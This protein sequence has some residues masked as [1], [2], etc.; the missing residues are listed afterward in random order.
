MPAGRR[1]DQQCRWSPRRLAEE[2]GWDPKLHDPDLAVAKGAAI[3]ALS[4]V[5]YRM[6]Q[7]ARE[8]AGS[9]A[10]GAERAAEVVQEVA[11]QYGLPAATVEELVDRKGRK[12]AAEGV[13]RARLDTRTPLRRETSTTWRSRTI[14]CPSANA[15]S[16]RETIAHDQ[17]RVLFALYEQAGT[18]VSEELSANNPLAD[19]SGRDRRA[20]RRS[21]PGSTPRSTSPWRSTPTGCWG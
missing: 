16:P 20:S 2:F 14:R 11:R 7:E 4:R 13:R 12:R 5:A 18:V 17:S 8:A 6:Q 1:V 3:F 9:E 21:R 10:E 19:G 15:G